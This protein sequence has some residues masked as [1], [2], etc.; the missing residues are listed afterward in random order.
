MTVP[1]CTPTVALVPLAHPSE[2]PPEPLS[3]W[4][5]VNCSFALMTGRAGNSAG[6][7]AYLERVAMRNALGL[8]LASVLAAVVIAGGWYFYSSRADQGAPKTTAARAAD[9]LPAKLAAK[10]DAEPPAAIAGKPAAPAVAA[11]PAPAPAV[12]PV[13]DTSTCTN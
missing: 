6:L 12:A 11:A 3:C 7:V 4:C 2:I 9:P 5:H 13:Q 10:D 8:M 1:S